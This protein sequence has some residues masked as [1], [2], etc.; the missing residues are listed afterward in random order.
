MPP[1]TYVFVWE[2]ESPAPLNYETVERAISDA[3]GVSRDEVVQMRVVL[4]TTGVRV[5]SLTSG[6]VYRLVPIAKQEV[7]E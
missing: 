1:P 7:E 5:T 3:T 6:Q 2:G 4:Y